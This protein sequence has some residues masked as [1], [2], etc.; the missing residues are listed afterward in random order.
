[1]STLSTATVLITAAL[2]LCQGAAADQGRVGEDF[3]IYTAP[4]R[5]IEVE[6]GRKL[7]LVCLG[8]GS[9]TVIFDIGVGDPAGDWSLVQPRVAKYTR[10]CSYDRAGIGF[11]DGSDNRGSS[12]EIVAD[13]R[14][15][16]STAA[17]DPPYILV[18]QSYG[19]MNVRLYYYL[20]PDDVLGMVLVEPAHEDQDEGFRMLSP[21]A[22]SREEWVSTRGDG[23]V[24]RAT[25]IDA[26]RRGLDPDSAEFSGCIVDPPD[27][28]P[29]AIKP[30]WRSMQFSEKFQRAQGAE[31]T[32]VFAESVDQLRAH[33]R[34]FGALPVIVLS[35][36]AEAR[37]LRDWETKR[38]REARYQ[39][40]LDLH[41]SLADA[42][43]RGEQRTIPGSDH[44]MMLSQPD[45]VVSAVRDVFTA[46][47]RGTAKHGH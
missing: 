22:L 1:M 31:E 24:S 33:R 23:G 47:A 9:P 36:S 5:L 29:D 46:V 4:Q 39:L 28:L 14:R 20:H 2:A 11:S 8:E 12:A 18:G 37:P 17:I 19:G 41:R 3:S 21:R 45:A 30:M 42:S 35:R 34:G 38:L 16:L 7:N 6:P 27:A 44:L 25:C 32:A 10:A 40:W 15:M 13:M 43:S 26:A